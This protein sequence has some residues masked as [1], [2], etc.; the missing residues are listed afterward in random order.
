M[1]HHMTH[2]AVNN[3]KGYRIDLC[4]EN[5]INSQMYSYAFHC[6]GIGDVVNI[7]YYHKCTA[8]NLFL[9]LPITITDETV[10]NFPDA[11][12]ANIEKSENKRSNSIIIHGQESENKSNAY[13]KMNAVKKDE[14]SDNEY[15]NIIHSFNVTNKTKHK[16]KQKLWTLILNRHW[17]GCLVIITT[18]VKSLRVMWVMQKQSDVPGLFNH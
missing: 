2:T 7:N 10:I 6:N 9:L 5:V 4:N 11:S 1:I 12:D 15:E 13:I 16:K 8:K 18:K 14:C 17:V 3:W